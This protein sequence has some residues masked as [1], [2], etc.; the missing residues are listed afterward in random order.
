MQIP[1]LTFTDIT[2]LLATSSITLLITAELA[3]LYHGRTTVFLNKKN[4][5]KA[6]LVIGILFLLTIAV[7]IINL[8]TI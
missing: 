3:S 7:K 8:I 2:F 5:E 1:P 6:A 4:L